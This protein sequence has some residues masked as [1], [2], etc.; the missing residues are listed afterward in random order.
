MKA[1]KEEEKEGQYEKASEDEPCI[2]Y[3]WKEKLTTRSEKIKYLK[4]ALRYWYSND[5]YGSEKTG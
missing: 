1:K 3:D 2:R 4:A 5:W